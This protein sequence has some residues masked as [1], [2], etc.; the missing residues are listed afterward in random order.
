MAIDN[1]KLRFYEQYY[2][3]NPEIEEVLI[4]T[5]GN[6]Q[7]R[8]LAYDS[9][10]ERIAGEPMPDFAALDWGPEIS[11]RGEEQFDQ[12]MRPKQHPATGDRPDL[13]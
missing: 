9:A 3:H 10:F 13:Q 1:G 2:A 5:A 11:R 8:R 7:W 12:R 4:D 6:V